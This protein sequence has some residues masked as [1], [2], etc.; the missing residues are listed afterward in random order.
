MKFLVESVGQRK[1]FNDALT[2]IIILC[3]ILTVTIISLI[4]IDKIDEIKSGCIIGIIQR[5]ILEKASKIDLLCYDRTDFYNEFI[6]ALDRGETQIAQS[7]SLVVNIISGITSIISIVAVIA[8]INPVIAIFQF[9]ACLINLVTMIWIKKVEYKMNLE[10]DPIARKRF[11]SRRVFY[12]A[13]YAKEI[14]LTNIKEPLLQQFY[15]SIEEERAVVK[16]YGFNMILVKLSNYVIG[17][18]LCVYCIPPLYMLYNTVVTNRITIS[19][20]SATHNANTNVFYT[21]NDM[22]NKIMELQNIGLYAENFKKFMEY[23]IKIENSIGDT[24]LCDRPYLLEVRNLSFKYE[25]D[26]DYI[27]KNVN[28]VI[29][30]NEK[31]AIVGHNGAGKTTFIKLLLRLYDAMEGGIYYNGRNIKEYDINDY[32]KLFGTVFQDFQIY[33]GTIGEN[34]MMDYT[35]IDDKP[36]INAALKKGL[37]ND[38]VEF[39]KDTVDTQITR[40]FYD[41]GTSLSGGEQQKLAISRLFIHKKPIAILDEPP[42]ALDVVAEHELNHSMLCEFKDSTII[43]ISHRLSTTRMTDK[44]YMFENGMIIEEGTHDE[45]MENSGDYAEMFRKQAQ[46]YA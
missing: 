5:E 20:M 39:L 4:I 24:V 7:I 15:N 35:S 9:I 10:S 23:D 40:E 18:T 12:Q 14:K 11:Y 1:T 16:K 46:Y 3:G 27:L 8:T 34:V 6:R 45:L 31:I 44:I 13:S 26:G 22:S 41:D 36:K 17:W 2:N 37:M 29:K 28:M 30:P 25:E 42:S 38:K 43:M 21:L 32:R 19:E 33:A